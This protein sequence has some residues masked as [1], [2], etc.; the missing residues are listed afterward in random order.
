MRGMWKKGLIRKTI[1]TKA[2]QTA[3]FI[4]NKCEIQLSADIMKMRKEA[5]NSPVTT[6]LLR[7]QK[8]QI[9]TR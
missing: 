9:L 3:M 7:F 6:F 1:L 2:A 8:G 4:R 5:I